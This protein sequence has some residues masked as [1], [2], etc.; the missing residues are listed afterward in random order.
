MPYRVK[1]VKI[2]ILFKAENV[3]FLN[4]VLNLMEGKFN[5]LSLYRHK[6]NKI[7]TMFAFYKN[8]IHSNKQV[9]SILTNQEI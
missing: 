1:P 9:T 3:M 2:A 7:K 8:C 6:K 4:E 5:V